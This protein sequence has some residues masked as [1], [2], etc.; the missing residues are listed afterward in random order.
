MAKKRFKLALCKDFILVKQFEEPLWTHK[1]K[2]A[3][4]NQWIC[5]EVTKLVTSIEGIP[6][7]VGATFL[8]NDVNGAA[9]LS[10]R[11]DNYK[12]IGVTKARPLAFMLKEIARLH[13]KA[14]FVKHNS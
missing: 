9:L 7:N 5:D 11:H 4:A 2:T 3:L 10:I 6:E 13:T 14:I 1:Y 8:G 12:G